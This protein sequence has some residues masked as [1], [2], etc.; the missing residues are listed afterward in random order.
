VQ[1]PIRAQTLDAKTT[2]M[3]DEERLAS[4]V[5]EEFH[6]RQRARHYPGARYAVKRFLVRT[7]RIAIGFGIGILSLEPLE[8]ASKTA[9]EQPLSS[10][11]PLDLI[12]SVLAAVVGIAAVVWAPR[13][14][15][16][17]GESREMHDARLA[18]EMRLAIE[19]ELRWR[20]KNAQALA[21]WQKT[22][23]AYKGRQTTAR[24]FGR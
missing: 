21:D 4:T 24:L 1:T 5:E 10:L 8:F 18:G 7:T 6:Q 15:F 20:W 9:L 3:L 14:A 2:Q 23:S 16:G 17:E 19:N 22:N 12:A 11:L 13:I